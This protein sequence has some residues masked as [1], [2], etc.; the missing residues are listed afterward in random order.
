MKE[1]KDRLVDDKRQEILEQIKRKNQSSSKI[2][3]KSKLEKV[4][5]L[6]KMNK[7]MQTDKS[8]KKKMDEHFKRLEE[9]RVEI[10]KMVENKSNYI[11]CLDLFLNILK[12]KRNFK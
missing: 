1:S 12:K 4:Q 10:E 3:D 6:I 8:I 7:T 9:Q 2:L 5:R 11:N